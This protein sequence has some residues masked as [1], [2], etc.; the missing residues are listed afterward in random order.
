MSA[1]LARLNAVVER[2]G[3]EAA[4]SRSVMLGRIEALTE[5]RERTVGELQKKLE[6]AEREKVESKHQLSTATQKM[7][8]L[9]LKALASGS[10]KPGRDR[11]QLYWESM[12][13]SNARPDA[14]SWRTDK[15]DSNMSRQVD[16]D[17]KLEVDTH[18]A[19]MR[20]QAAAE[21]LKDDEAM[22]A[23]DSAGAWR[24]EGAGGRPVGALVTP[25]GATLS[26]PADAW[27]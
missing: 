26:W 8:N 22:R 21:E 13:N 2:L 23:A 9:S 3:G 17:H 5:E 7:R 14:L 11:Q 6:H 12:K 24:K 16:L 18:L 4:E 25:A 10:A 15:D 19:N 20:N 1:E 27:S